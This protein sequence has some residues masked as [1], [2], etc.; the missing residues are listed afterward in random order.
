[1]YVSEQETEREATGIYR[2]QSTDVPESASQKKRKHRAVKTPVFPFRQ[3]LQIKKMGYRKMVFTVKMCYM[4]MQIHLT[5]TAQINLYCSWREVK[6]G[7]KNKTV[8]KIYNSTWV[9]Q[10][11]PGKIRTVASIYIKLLFHRFI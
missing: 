6:P 8:C 4:N 5:K 9:I 3:R 2:I 11:H 7:I 10:M 1:M